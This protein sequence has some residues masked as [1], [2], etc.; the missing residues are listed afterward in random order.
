M[1]STDD[2]SFDGTLESFFYEQVEDACQEKGS[3]LEQDVEAYLVHLLAHYARRPQVQGRTSP[4]LATQYLA[5]RERGATALREV[6]DRA[7]YIAGVVPRS[8]ERSPVNVDYVAGIGEAAYREIY[9]QRSRLEIF[10]RLAEGFREILAVL[11]RMLGPAKPGDDLLA[12]YERWR[13]SADPADAKRLIHAG[14]LLDPE[15]SDLL[16]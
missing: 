7:L 9:A 13:R 2:L 6:G 5:A 12:L 14:V 15:T 3:S 8:L 11:G 10:A 16:Q 1:S 4:A